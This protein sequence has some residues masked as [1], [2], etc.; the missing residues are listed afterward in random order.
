MVFS[1]TPMDC[2]SCSRKLSWAA[3]KDAA[4][5]PCRV[6]LERGL[7]QARIPAVVRD[8]CAR[9]READVPVR[10]RGVLG[11]HHERRCPTQPRDATAAAREALI[12]TALSKGLRLSSIREV[13]P[14]LDDIYRRALHATGLAIQR[15]TA[16]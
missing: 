12:K 11:V 5:C 2:V 13:A 6:A 3:V 8:E 7:H 10:L 1:T 16:A 14:S 9:R 15:G 4:L